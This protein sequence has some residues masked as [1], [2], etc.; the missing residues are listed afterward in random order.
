MLARL[1]TLRAFVDPR[2][3]SD[4]RGLLA[5]TLVLLTVEVVI[6]AAVLATGL[7][8]EGPVAWI[9]EAAMLWLAVAA[10]VRRLHDCGRSAWWIAGGTAGV[11]TWCFV[12]TVGIM[13]AQGPLAFAPGSIWLTLTIG[14]VTVPVLALIVWL[15]CEPGTPEPNAHGPAPDASGF[16]EPGRS[17]EGFGT[18][19]TVPAA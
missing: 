2:G 7:A 1:P 12:L 14:A 10:T 11:M 16:S 15:H 18:A 8:W 17:G 19:A 6:A 9:G 13:L 3:R 4:R 5:V